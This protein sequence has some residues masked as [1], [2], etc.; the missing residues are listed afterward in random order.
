MTQRDQKI[1]MLLVLGILAL[2]IGI[3]LVKT[4][5][6]DPISEY[7]NKISS[8]EDKKDQVWQQINLIEAG[9]KDLEKAKRMSLPAQ[10]VKAAASYDQYLVDLLR[11][12]GLTEVFVQGP[13]P[14]DP[15]SAPTVPTAVTAPKKAGHTIL[16]YTVRAKGSLAAVV[17]ALENLQRTPIMHRVRGLSLGRQ[18]NNSSKE[19]NTGKLLVQMTIEAMIVAGVKADQEA[20][21]KPN[22]DAK[23]PTESYPRKYTDIARKNIFI[24]PVP[25]PPQPPVVDLTEP[26]AEEKIIPEF[27]RLTHTDALAQEAFLRT[28]IFQMPE[29]RL[30]SKPGSGYD[31]FTIKNEERTKDLVRARVLRIDERDVYFQVKD[32]VYGVHVGQNIWQ[33]MRR[34]L[35]D[36]ELENLELTDLV[37]P[38]DP[39]SEPAKRFGPGQ[40][41]GFAP[42]GT[43][44][45]KAPGGGTPEIRRGPGQGGGNNS[46]MRKGGKSGKKKNNNNDKQD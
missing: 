45:R 4:S 8:L 29:T 12:S 9:R 41:S 14:A 36:E 3:V 38:Y 23:L 16:N 13:P 40:K 27:V 1:V 20:K 18:D 32:D 19:A 15:K 37:L 2:G 33:A 7:N 28:L 42:P 10:Q 24:G 30:R 35:S 26:T 25:L 31:W 11:E 44:V 34:P 21:L 46:D 5:F 22:A 43:D 6:V 39:A 17:T